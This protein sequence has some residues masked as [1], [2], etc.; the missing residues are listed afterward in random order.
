[1]ETEGGGLA[2]TPVPK[3]GENRR[4]PSSLSDDEGLSNTTDDDG[5]WLVSSSEE[6][7]DHEARGQSNPDAKLRG[8]L[9]IRLFPAFKSGKHYFGSDYNLADKSQFSVDSVGDCPNECRC[10]PMYLLQLIGIKIAGYQHTQPGRVKLYGFIAARERP[11]CLR[12]YVYRREIEDC[13]SVS[14]K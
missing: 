9:P 8:P 5:E 13:E 6:D 14:V 2:A 10:L 12:S 1:M 4:L 11:L 7:E 3:R